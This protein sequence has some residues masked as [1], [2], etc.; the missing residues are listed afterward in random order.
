METWKLSWEVEKIE[1]NVTQLL[2]E[3]VLKV[4]L[5]RVLSILKFEV[6]FFESR[7][8]IIKAACKKMKIAVAYPAKI[9]DE[10]TA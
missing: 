2:F 1:K 4:S 6:V 8:K 10:K 3:K 5:N 9:V 7:A